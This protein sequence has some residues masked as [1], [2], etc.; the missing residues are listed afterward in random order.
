M[1]NRIGVGLSLFLTMCFANAGQDNHVHNEGQMLISQQDSQWF[2]QFNIPATNAFG[3]EHQP[4][5]EQQKQAINGFLTTV[6]SAKNVLQLDGDCKLIQSD[7]NLSELLNSKMDEATHEK[8]HAHEAH[9]H[10][11]DAEHEHIGEHINV[12]F[13]YLFTC[14]D[15]VETIEIS[16]FDNTLQLQE[17]SAQWI[18]ENGQGAK[19][20]SKNIPQLVIIN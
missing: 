19:T 6:Q 2:F 18:T 5:N 1:N 8:D 11:D 16:L 4:E 7:E 13:S 10:E 20:I 9:H 14:Q 15:P 12:E 3:F 17:L